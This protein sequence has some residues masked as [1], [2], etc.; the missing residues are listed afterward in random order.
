MEEVDRG[1][2][3]GIERRKERKRVGT[4]RIR[5]GSKVRASWPARVI[6]LN[7]IMHI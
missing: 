3:R 6:G 5:L 7:W 4:E 1:R 2:V